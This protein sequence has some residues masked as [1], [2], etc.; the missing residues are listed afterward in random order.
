MHLRSTFLSLLLVRASNSLHGDAIHKRKQEQ[1]ASDKITNVLTLYNIAEVYFGL[2]A[3]LVFQRG[4][5]TANNDT[6]MS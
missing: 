2:K 3:Y 4:L 1:D 5:L 6:W